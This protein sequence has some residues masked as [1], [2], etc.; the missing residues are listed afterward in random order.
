MAKD[1]RLIFLYEDLSHDS[2]EST[3]YYMH[4]ISV[5]D[6]DTLCF[7]DTTLIFVCTFYM[8]GH[9]MGLHMNGAR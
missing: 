2:M 1:Q 6:G 8:N 7:R 3:V 5:G 9:R 4:G